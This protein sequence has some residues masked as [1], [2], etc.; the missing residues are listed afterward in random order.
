LIKLLKLML[1]RNRGK[2]VLSRA[3]RNRPAIQIASVR[4]PYVWAER[5]LSGRDL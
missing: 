5:A 4:A 1:D 2:Q 3:G